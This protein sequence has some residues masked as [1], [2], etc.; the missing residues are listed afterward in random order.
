MFE[1]KPTGEILADL[2]REE[3]AGGDDDGEEQGLD[4]H[5]EAPPGA[6][7]R[8]HRISAAVQ[9][10]GEIDRPEDEEGV[11][12]IGFE[13]LAVAQDVR[14][15]EGGGHEHG[16]GQDDQAVELQPQATEIAPSRRADS[17]N[18]RRFRLD[19]QPAGNLV[20]AR[21]LPSQGRAYWKI[22]NQIL[23]CRTA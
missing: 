9:A 18:R 3:E 6:G 22:V 7:Q 2:Q 8:A 17:R 19:F 21:P 11:D 1:P 15:E 4:R 20:H 14:G 12:A 16:I 5:G 13:G 10:D 23:R